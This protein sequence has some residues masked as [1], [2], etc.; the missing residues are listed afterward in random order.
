MDKICFA[1][2]SIFRALGALGITA[3]KMNVG[4]QIPDQT[5]KD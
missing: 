4:A 1:T 3:K 5:N 2:F